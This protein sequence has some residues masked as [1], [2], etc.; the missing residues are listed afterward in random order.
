MVASCFRWDDECLF[1]VGISGEEII[2]KIDIGKMNVWTAA[3]NCLCDFR[4]SLRF[5]RRWQSFTAW[6]H[7]LVI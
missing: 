2:I 1:F 6:C 5:S 3:S 4:F 7:W